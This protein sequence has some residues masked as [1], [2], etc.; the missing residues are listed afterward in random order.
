[1]ELDVFGFAP[2]GSLQYIHME[3]AAHSGLFSVL[4]MK[5]Y[6]FFLICILISLVTSSAIAACRAKGFSIEDS[7]TVAKA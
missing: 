4:H 2:L 7:I 3:P 1:M 6:S 5:R